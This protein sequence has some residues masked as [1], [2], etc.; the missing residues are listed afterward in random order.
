MTVSVTSHL[1]V[2]PR[3]QSRGSR[4]GNRVARKSLKNA[5]QIILI[6]FLKCFNVLRINTKILRGV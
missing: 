4:L 3:L 2:R 6:H 5:N 1:L